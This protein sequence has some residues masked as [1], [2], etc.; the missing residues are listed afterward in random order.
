MP[1]Q[2]EKANLEE[3]KIDCN[4]AANKDNLRGEKRNHSKAGRLTDTIK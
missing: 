1:K 3:N 2:E 4:Q